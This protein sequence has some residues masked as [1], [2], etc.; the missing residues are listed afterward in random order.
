M[1]D[2]DWQVTMASMAAALAR[3]P[4]GTRAVFPLRHGSMRAGLYAPIGE[5]AQQPHDQDEL[6]IVSAGTATFVKAGE[7]R[8]VARHDM[9]L[10]EA[11]TAHR[12]EDFSAD[13]SAWVIFWG[14]EGGEGHAY[15]GGSINGRD[16][17]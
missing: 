11:G 7:R 10:V 15:G 13:F 2:T 4:G 1:E 3:D 5:D 14:P 8:P 6:Y 16:R 12:F 9:L 17:A